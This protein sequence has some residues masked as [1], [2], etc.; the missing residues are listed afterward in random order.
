MFEFVMFTVISFYFCICWVGFLFALKSFIFFE[1]QAKEFWFPI[2][3][4]T[5]TSL[6]W[7]WKLS[8]GTYDDIQ[9]AQFLL[10]PCVVVFVVS[11][12]PPLCRAVKSFHMKQKAKR[13]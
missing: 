13:R 1:K 11:S 12:I 7:V 2:A 4:V 8:Y 10:G 9:V 3:V 5:V 6:I